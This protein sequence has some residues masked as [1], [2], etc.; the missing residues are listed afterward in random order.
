MKADPKTESV[1]MNVVKQCF[2]A[3]AKR[4]LDAM[5]AFF[6]PDPDASCSAL[7]LAASSLRGSLDKDADLLGG[8]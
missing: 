8:A 5:L 7:R 4:D 1:V 6:A 2:E 3:F